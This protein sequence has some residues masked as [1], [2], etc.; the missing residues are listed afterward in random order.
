VITP[1][2]QHLCALQRFCRGGYVS[3]QQRHTGQDQAILA[4]RHALYL[5]AQQRHPAP[6]SGNTR[7]WA[8]INVVT[9]NPEPDEVLKMAACVQHT[10]LKAA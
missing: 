2:H 9:L 3:P 8:L 6:W 10:Q 5:Q 4:A 7:D 1:K